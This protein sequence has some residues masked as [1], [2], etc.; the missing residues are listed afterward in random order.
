MGALDGMTTNERLFEAGLMQEFDEARKA[1][2]A[3]RMIALLVRVELGDQAR[4]IVDD[5]LSN[6]ERYDPDRLHGYL[7]RLTRE[8]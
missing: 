6:P 4:A 7:D 5:V 1:L 8:R 3:E 2:D